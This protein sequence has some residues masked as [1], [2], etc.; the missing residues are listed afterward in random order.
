MCSYHEDGHGQSPSNYDTEHEQANLNGKRRR[1]NRQRSKQKRPSKKQRNA[2]KL[3]EQEEFHG[4][5]DHEGNQVVQPPASQ[6]PSASPQPPSLM[7]SK[8][9]SD[10]LLEQADSSS[11]SSESVNHSNHSSASQDQPPSSAMPIS[12]LSADEMSEDN[13]LHG[14]YLPKEVFS[15]SFSRSPSPT[16]PST[17][18]LSFEAESRIQNDSGGSDPSD[19]KRKS[20]SALL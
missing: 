9:S 16:H 11:S 6:I 13:D 7:L 2:R 18:D 15:M 14:L 4:F 12:T 20:A 17:D 19:A 5:S 1:G 3:L 10:E 8:A